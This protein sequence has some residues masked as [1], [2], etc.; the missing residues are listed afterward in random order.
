MLLLLASPSGPLWR[1]PAR[2]RT[3]DQD[4]WRTVSVARMIEVWDHEVLQVEKGYP[5]MANGIISE[6]LCRS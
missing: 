4:G 3:W 6:F 5:I 1:R 2:S